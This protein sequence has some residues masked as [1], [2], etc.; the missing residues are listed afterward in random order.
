VEQDYRRHDISDRVWEVLGPHLLG[1]N[2]TWGSN[3]KNKRQFIN[4]VFC[5][6][7]TGSPWRDLPPDYGS[8]KN[9]H[10]RFLPLSISLILLF[11]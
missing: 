4:A 1:R 10:R 3:T 7:R 8:W 11:A 9:I 5:I 2:G 6:L